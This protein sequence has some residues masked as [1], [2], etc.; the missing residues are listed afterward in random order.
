VLTALATRFRRLRVVWADGAYA[1]GV[2]EQWV[3]GLRSWR[4]VR[5]EIVRKPKGQRGFAVLPWRWIV[6][7]TLRGSA[8]GDGSSQSTSVCRRRPRHSFTFIHIAMIRLMLR[9]LVSV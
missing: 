5:L 6:E 9:R 3:R 8:D 1:G 7:R 4:K 2:L